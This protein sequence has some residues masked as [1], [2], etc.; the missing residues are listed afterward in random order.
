MRE[1]YTERHKAK[2]RGLLAA[3]WMA[4]SWSWDACAAKWVDA[5]GRL[6]A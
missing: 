5:I 3:K 2:Q 6:T 4:E 1:V